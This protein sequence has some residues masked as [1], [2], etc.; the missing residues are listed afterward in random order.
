LAERLVQQVFKNG[1]RPLEAVRADIRQVIGNH[2]HLRL[3]RIKPGLGNPKRSN[4]VN[5]MKNYFL[6]SGYNHY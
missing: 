5:S 3:L 1:P 2:I 6:L 4:H